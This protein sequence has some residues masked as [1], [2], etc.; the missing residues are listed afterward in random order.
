MLLSF[1]RMKLW[2]CILMYTHIKMAHPP[3]YD[4][5]IYSPTPKHNV[6]YKPIHILQHV[7]AIYTYRVYINNIIMPS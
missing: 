5:Y 7:N 1:T 4:I 2:M 6:I 3:I